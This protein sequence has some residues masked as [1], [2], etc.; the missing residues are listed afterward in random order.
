LTKSMWSI[1]KNHIYWI[2]FLFRSPQ[3]FINWKFT[4]Q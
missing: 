2:L 3:Y 1:Q 4:Y